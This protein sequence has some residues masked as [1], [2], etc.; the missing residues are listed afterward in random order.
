M[1]GVEQLGGLNAMKTGSPHREARVWAWAWLCLLSFLSGCSILISPDEERLGPDLVDA[2]VP[3]GARDGGLCPGPD[4]CSQGVVVTCSGGEAST[5]IC[6][7]GCSS[8]ATACAQ[9][10]PSNV[11]LGWTDASSDVLAFD[12]VGTSTIDTDQ[13]PANRRVTQTDGSVICV[14]PARIV[15]VGSSTRLRVTGPVPLAIV[16]SEVVVID[17]IVDAAAR[18]DLPGPGGFS[19]GDADQPAGRGPTAG[20]AGGGPPSGG[21]SGG[22]G[23]G[24]C[25][26]GGDGGGA[27][28]AAGGNAAT[29]GWDLTPLFGGSGGGRGHVPLPAPASSAG[30][31]GAGGGALQITS[32]GSISVSGAVTVAGGGG[33]SGLASV[34][35]AGGGAGSGGSLLLEAPEIR[36]ASGG[37]LTATGGGGG[38]GSGRGGAGEDGSNGALRVDRAPG[39]AAGARGGGDGGDSGAG[40][41]L[42]GLPGGIVNARGSLGGGGGGG[43]GCILVRTVDGTWQPA[44]STSPTG[45]T[46]LKVLPLEIR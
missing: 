36:L 31:G 23:A 9:L 38:G 15:Y 22:G 8:T 30:A 41:E 14:L 40:T 42:D 16:A 35:A 37:I 29:A 46:G 44:G 12:D 25:G 21:G 13:C 20:A 17:G 27:P 39:G 1:K 34:E 4:R 3:D 33:R 24:R 32:L 45:A 26:G 43:A 10:H 7:L 6:P 18:L 2:S 11:G 19:G 5:T 28:K